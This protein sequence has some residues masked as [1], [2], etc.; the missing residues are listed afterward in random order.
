M[1]LRPAQDLVA[2]SSKFSLRSF[3]DKP[4][5]GHT[6]HAPEGLSTLNA[7]T[8]ALPQVAHPFQQAMAAATAAAAATAPSPLPPPPGHLSPPQG[9]GFARPSLPSGVSAAAGAPKEGKFTFSGLMPATSPVQMQHK[10]ILQ[11][12]Q[13]SL[14]STSTKASPQ[15]E[16]SETLRLKAQV[17]SLTDRA[18]QLNANLASTSESVVK[19]NKALMSERAQFHAKYATLTKKLEAT[20]AALAEAD[21]LP[22]E[23]IKNANLLNTKILELQQEN[24][25]LTQARAE[26]EQALS[27]KRAEIAT[28]VAAAK[29]TTPV[30]AVDAD[31]EARCQSLQDNYTTLAA[32][33]SM[34]LESKHQ[35]QAQLD[36]HVEMLTAAHA[37]LEEANERVRASQVEIEAQTLCLEQATQSLAESQESAE[38]F[39]AQV[40]ASQLEIA[41]S[42]SLVDSLDAKLA[43]LRVQHEQQQHEQQQQTDA[44]AEPFAPTE[45]AEV[46]EVACC[47]PRTARVEELEKAARSAHE[48]ALLA[49][50]LTCKALVEE[51]RFHEAVAK[52][53]RACLDSGAPE[54]AMVAHVYTDENDALEDA[55]ENAP[56]PPLPGGIRETRLPM[57]TP[58]DDTFLQCQ[59]NMHCCAH[60]DAQSTGSAAED[61]QITDVRTNAFVKAVSEDLK[62]HMQDCQQLYKTSSITG[63]A[64]KL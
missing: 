39:R 9:G 57:G 1:S 53:A 38:A 17:L 45:V 25:Q 49:D 29:A 33:H 61:P 14:Q 48:S 5:S 10:M 56:L 13:A 41:Q 46:V 7:Y 63:I 23:A 42:D 12:Q 20:Q 2:E 6:D 18:N 4:S 36:Q 30:A 31:L 51:A 35:M 60:E 43:D 62:F 32:Q 8:E 54:H 40:D 64:L 34:V 15:Q 19:G 22:K 37:Q 47:C 28:A 59:A 21:A 44:L 55:L 52:R 16:T 50:E 26:L 58:F 27:D 3:F 24:V 11:A